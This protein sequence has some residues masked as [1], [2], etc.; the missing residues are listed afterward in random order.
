MTIPP[1]FPCVALRCCSRPSRPKIGWRLRLPSRLPWMWGKRADS[2]DLG[3]AD[4]ASFYCILVLIKKLW[5]Y[6][7]PSPLSSLSLSLPRWSEPLARSA[8]GV[9]GPAHPNP[10]PSKA[11]PGRRPLPG[12]CP[13]PLPPPNRRCFGLLASKTTAAAPPAPRSATARAA[14]GT[15]TRRPR[16][17]AELRGATRRA[18]GRH[19]GDSCPHTRRPR[20]S[21]PWGQPAY[22]CLCGP[23]VSTQP[24]ERTS[25]TTSRDRGLWGHSPLASLGPGVSRVGELAEQ[26]EE[27]GRAPTVFS[28]PQPSNSKVR[29][30]C[31]GLGA[32]RVSGPRTWWGQ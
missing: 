12:P 30:G 17:R 4:F 25:W 6:H 16:S 20:T 23:Q 28:C 15:R 26:V 7:H 13:S 1:P 31:A 18:P 21:P 22:S 8:E 3:L 19:R 14:G 27:R 32:G 24:R 9:S 10:A 11:P 2:S 29:Q 5:V